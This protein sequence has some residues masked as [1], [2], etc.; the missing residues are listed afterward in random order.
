MTADQVIEVKEHLKNCDDCCGAI[1]DEPDDRV[2]VIQSVFINEDNC[3]NPPLPEVSDEEM[4]DIV[5]YC[6]TLPLASM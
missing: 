4:A 1:L 3:E 5:A 2:C 6:K